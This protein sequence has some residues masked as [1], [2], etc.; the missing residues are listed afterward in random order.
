MVDVTGGA[1]GCSFFVSVATVVSA[2]ASFKKAAARSLTLSLFVFSFSVF[3]A[4][5]GDF[6]AST[7]PIGAAVDCLGCTNFNT[8]SSASFS[9][10][11][12]LH[13]FNSFKILALP[14]S[15]TSAACKSFNAL[16]KSLFFL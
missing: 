15:M 3:V 4:V 9:A 8:S 14:G 11:S 13:R 10:F 1:L 16:T 12:I 5:S 6:F 2:L 7:E